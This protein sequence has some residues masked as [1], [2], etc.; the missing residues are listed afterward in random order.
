MILSLFKSYSNIKLKDIPKE[1]L[2]NFYAA[3]LR[4]P[5][6][7][8]KD[9]NNEYVCIRKE[10]ANEIAEMLEEVLEEYENK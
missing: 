2:L 9:D 1:M 10:T 5:E 8:L 6:F 7:T 3:E 4:V